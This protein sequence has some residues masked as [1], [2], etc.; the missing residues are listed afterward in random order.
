MYTYEHKLRV[1]YGETD[2]MGVVY[3][4]NYPLYFEEARSEM[5]RN[6]AVPY[7]ELEKIGVIMPVVD[8]HIRYMKPAHY[9]EVL[10][11][12]VQVV[13]LP[14]VRIICRYEVINEQGVLLT[15]AETTLAFI[16]KETG[17]PV[18][19]PEAWLSKLRP[20]FE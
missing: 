15:E 17:R 6:L 5:M 4:G 7:A 3:H 14:T 16:S 11:V 8:M 2:Q 19:V 20:Y 1:R 13:K 9:D 18:I 12:K 10:T